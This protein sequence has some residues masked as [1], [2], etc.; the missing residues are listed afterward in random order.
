MSGVRRVKLGDVAAS[1]DYGHTASASTQRV[2]PKFLRIT[3]IQ[4]GAVDWDSVPFCAAT[5]AEESSSR[6][7]PG[8]IVFARTGATTGKSFL[9]R[10]C[11]ER[12]V[13]ASYLIRV[14]PKLVID[15]A[16]LAR[17]FES[18]E[19]WNQ[20]TK[21]ARGAAQ[22][23]VNATVLRD[24]TV[25]LPS[26][27]EQRRI[28]AILDQA[29]TL[30]RHRRAAVERFEDLSRT[31]FLTMFGDPLT[32]P[33]G[34]NDDRT[35]GEVADIV[36]GITKGRKV[37]GLPV[38]E[39]PYL[40]VANVQDR[41]LKLDIVKTIEA[42]EA[43]IARYRLKADD[44]L[45]TEG[46]D[47]DKLGRGTLWASEMPECIHQNHVFRVRLTSNALH[48]VF[49]NWLVGSERGKRYFLRSAKQTTGIASINMGQ[50]RQFPLLVPPLE[51][52]RAFA[53]RVR[54][55]EALKAQH[56]THLSHLDALFASLQHRA[57]RG[58]L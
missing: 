22:P 2:G 56:R 19:Y 21:S 14:R 27:E 39:V 52:Q 41:H 16:F 42:T 7:V 12:A 30:R 8:D 18:Q 28:A 10:T 45:L 13:F 50:L 48:P 38:R 46:G 9:V 43:E 29:D 1:V 36:S 53:E 34:W 54:A 58:E 5:T 51:L 31:V 26:L 55:I 11:P 15:P 32:N 23:G 47:P 24:L 3:D 4:N 17:F 20:I 44:L 6:L 33:R 49:L 37:N 25:P 35:L 40:A 57:F